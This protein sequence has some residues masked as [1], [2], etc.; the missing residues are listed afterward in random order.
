VLALLKCVHD[1]DWTGAEREFKLA[2]EL[3]PGSAD[4][5][6]HYGWLCAALERYEEALVLV[7]R[8]Q[9]LDPLVHRA[10]VATTL[11]R[12]GRYDEAL[13]SALRCVEFEPEY[14]RGRSTLGWAYLKKGM[15]DEGLAQ[16]RRSVS[17]APNN[18]LYL[19]QLGEAY[20]LAGKLGEAREVL[21]QLE[22]LSL[23]RYVSPYHLAYVYTGLGDQ[24]RAMDLLERAHAERAGSVY[25]VKGSFLFTPLR[26]HPRFE[27]L[28][29]KMNLA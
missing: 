19:A 24:E 3:S 8:A 7:Q 5:Y 10:D 28:L 17:L 16:L 11:L 15:P 4:I 21:R 27:A 12:A 18:T 13:E 22:Q 29:R 23:Q 6:D 26:S 2:L 20:G 9:E 25:G 14:A 1:F